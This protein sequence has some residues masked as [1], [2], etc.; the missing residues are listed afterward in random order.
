[1][2]RHDKAQTKNKLRSRPWQDE[3]RADKDQKR[4]DRGKVRTLKTR[5]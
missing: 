5:T 1:M 2:F 3:T 4:Q